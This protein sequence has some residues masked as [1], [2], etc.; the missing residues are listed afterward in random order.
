MPRHVFGGYSERLNHP[1]ESKCPNQGGRSHSTALHVTVNTGDLERATHRLTWGPLVISLSSESKACRHTL[2]HSKVWQSEN[3]AS[4][5]FFWPRLRAVPFATS[6]P[7]C[8]VWLSAADITRIFLQWISLSQFLHQQN[9]DKSVAIL[10]G[11][12]EVS[13]H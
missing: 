7:H 13:E 6:C 8:A 11:V 3:K 9:E 2:T 12:V 4:V 5:L 10:K 1:V